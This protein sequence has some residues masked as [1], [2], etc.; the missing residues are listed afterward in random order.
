MAT[1]SRLLRAARHASLASRAAASAA[2]RLLR[3]ARNASLA[4]RPAASAASRAAAMAACGTVAAA[5]SRAAA[6]ASR[7]ERAAAAVAHLASD[8]LQSRPIRGDASSTKPHGRDAPRFCLAEYLSSANYKRLP[9]D[10]KTPTDK[11]LESDEALWALYER[12]CKAHNKERDHADMARRFKI[13]KINAD[14]VH[15]WNTYLPPDPVEA[16][17]HR[18]K[19]EEAKLLRS[20]GQDVSYFDVWH[21]PSELG[22]FADGGDPFITESNMRL[23]KEIED[24]EGVKA[25]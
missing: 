2:S 4:S 13:F 15:H 24:A 7:S 23:L 21:L 9:D 18:E 3:A 8:V 10:V 20:K 12:W 14:D 17:I 22:P 5:A 25:E 1:A 11:D 19:R 16:A 6:M